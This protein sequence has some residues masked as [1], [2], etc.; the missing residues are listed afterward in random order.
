MS[1]TVIADE[2]KHLERE[3]HKEFDIIVD[4][5]EAKAKDQS[6]TVPITP[7]TITNM[8]KDTP[9]IKKI[10]LLPLHRDNAR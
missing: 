6:G 10:R 7:L 2:Q 3:T 9:A 5:I 1:F 4:I 8:Q